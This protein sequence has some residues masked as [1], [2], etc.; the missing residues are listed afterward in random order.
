[1][2]VRITRRRFI[3]LVPLSA[4]GAAV[5]AACGA[6]A[7]P[8][9][10]PAA[11]K[12]PAAATTAPA[13][14]ATTAPAAAAT[15]A[16]AAATT[17]PAAAAAT[18][19]PAA[20]TATKAPA[21]SSGQKASLTVWLS[22]SY[23]KDAD[24]LQQAT[25]KAW[26]EQNKVDITI[27]M[28]S[29]TVLGPQLSAAL[30]SK[31][32]PDVLSLW[33]PALAP[34]M[35]RAGVLLDVSDVVKSI[36]SLGGGIYDRAITALTIDGKQW[37]VPNQMSTEIFYVRKDLVTAKNM[38]LPETWEDVIAVAKAINNPPTIWGY[39][40]QL[41]TASYDAEISL[42]SQLASYGASPFAE[43]G[44]TINIDNDGTRAVLKLIKEGWDAGVMPKDALT[45]DDSGNNKAYQTGTA[46]MVYNTGSVLAYLQQNDKDLLGKTAF[47]PSPAGPK[48]H[49]VE[50]YVYGYGVTNL[51]KFP[52]ECKA[53]ITSL[54]Q[55]DYYQKYIVA[56]GTN[57]LPIYKDLVSMDIFKDT[58][59]HVI[60]DSLKNTVALGYPGPTTE[61]ALDVWK[62]HTMTQMVDAVLTGNK[63][64]DDAIKLVVPMIQ[65][66]YNQ[67]NK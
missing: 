55:L 33:D 14:A 42:T 50:G 29:S 28:D 45:W 40:E 48:G 47:I 54:M 10:A 43:D 4:L 13:A 18:T 58:N 22:T 17:A 57:L 32:L 6:S 11:T 30:E 60:I 36:S 38:K 62:K 46:A 67:F 31:K 34:Q 61:A 41:G 24:N 2:K 53:L 66:S 26:G 44:K 20:A 7:T 21:Q 8:T 64:P 65:Q 12:A 15:T 1:M 39:G 3:T 51:T 9:T 27:V 23:T 37:G 5:L 52:D 19:A 25:V 63:S 56:A 16:P 49:I 59:T 35:H